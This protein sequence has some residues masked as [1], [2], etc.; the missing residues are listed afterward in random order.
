MSNPTQNFTPST[1][2]FD[3]YGATIV[4][5]EPNALLEQ[6]APLIGTELRATNPTSGYKSALELRAGDR[7][8]GLVM[9]GGRNPDPYAVAS[10][11]DAEPFAA[12]IRSLGFRH[13]VSR[14]DVCIDI[15][16]AGVF[17]LLSDELRAVAVRTGLELQL[18]QDPERPER[19][20]T[21]Y[22][23]SRKSRG[24]VRLY[25]KGKKDDPSR[26]NWVRFE[27]ELKPSEPAQKAH[28]A[29]VDPLDALGMIKWVRTFVA[30]QFVF[31]ASPGPI[32]LPNVGDDERSTDAML[33]QWGG[34]LVRLAARSGGWEALG[35][36]LGRRLG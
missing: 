33:H 27:C 2:R 4:D 12:A 3:W 8:T 1:P 25:E 28:L 20:R 24:F 19:G 13:R 35:R 14:A 7:R 22:V 36:D 6:L 29:L 17:E 34:L 21:L 31:A 18:W 5:T 10:G 9:W 23:G 15:D 11:Q 26:P 30:D 32:R 16:E